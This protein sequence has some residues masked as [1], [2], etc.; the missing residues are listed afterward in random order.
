M[1]LHYWTTK[2]SAPLRPPSL[3]ALSAL[4]ALPYTHRPLLLSLRPRPCP[5]VAAAAAAY[6]ITVLI[7]YEPIASR[8]QHAR[9]HKA[10]LG[11]RL[12]SLTSLE[13]H[14]E[15]TGQARSRRR[16]ECFVG[17]SPTRPKVLCCTLHTVLHPRV[18]SRLAGP[19]APIVVLAS[20]LGISSVSTLISSSFSFGARASSSPFFFFLFPG[21]LRSCPSSSTYK[22]PQY[23]RT[24]DEGNRNPPT[25]ITRRIARRRTSKSSS[26]KAHFALPRATTPPSL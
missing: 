2:H 15:P 25:R 20:L 1:L 3:Q 8:Q 17:G 23:A 18:S 14:Q 21:R 19:A 12:S 22:I 16:P 9:S 13:Q 4:H 24:E 10:P 7:K 6:L 5:P 11:R 26:Q